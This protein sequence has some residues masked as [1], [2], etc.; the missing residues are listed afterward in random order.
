[1]KTDDIVN[2]MIECP[3]QSVVIELANEQHISLNGYRHA[4]NER[5]EPIIVLFAKGHISEGS[6]I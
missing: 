3:K 1:M 5:G 2:V 4:E 6:N